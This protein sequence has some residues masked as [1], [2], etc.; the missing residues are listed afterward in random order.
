MVRASLAEYE[1]MGLIPALSICFFSLL[2]Y[3]VVGIF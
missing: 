2:E 3:E 1:D